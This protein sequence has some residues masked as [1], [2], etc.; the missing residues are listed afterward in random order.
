MCRDGRQFNLHIKRNIYIYIYIL[1]LN[2]LDYVVRSEKKKRSILI[3]VV[4]ASEE[5]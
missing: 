2:I 3:R 4:V 5:C 1:L